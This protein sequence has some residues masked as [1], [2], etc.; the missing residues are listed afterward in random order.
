MFRKTKLVNFLCAIIIGIL[1][2]LVVVALLFATGVIS[3]GKTE[4]VIATGGSE[5][6]YDGT[7]LTNRTWKITK[8]MLKEGH[9]LTFS[10]SGVQTNVGESDNVIEILI[11]DELGADVTGDYKITFEYGKLKINPRSVLITCDTDY[12]TGI[13]TV[14][15]EVSDLY[16]GL[17]F[18]HRITV[19]PLDNI[20]ITDEKAPNF[21]VAIYDEFGSDVSSNYRI[22]MNSSI[23]P[24]EGFGEGTEEG[25][26]EGTEEGTEEGTVEGTE[27]SSGN[28][29]N[30]DL[31]NKPPVDEVLYYITASEDSFVYLREGSSGEYNGKSW[32]AAPAFPYVADIIYSPSYLPSFALASGGYTTRSIVIEP[33]YRSFALPYYT[34][35]VSG[36]NTFDIQT[37]DA[38]YTGNGDI[39]TA[40]YYTADYNS[41]Q[42][43]TLP[44]ELVE[45]E[46]VYR[47]YVYGQYMNVPD[48]ELKNHLLDVIEE[49][50]F[51]KIEDRYML[52]SVVS[53]YIKSCAK[54]NLEYDSSIDEADDIVLAFLE[55]KEGVCRHFASAATL[56]FRLLGVP[57]RYTY[58][59]VGT[60]VSGERTEIKGDQAHAWV[61]VY[62]DGI[63]WVQ[64]EVTPGY[65]GDE[66]DELI[67]KVKY[68]KPYKV[69]YDTKGHSYPFSDARYA[70]ISL[71]GF[72]ELA[73]LGYRYEFID[74]DSHTDPGTYAVSV[75]GIRFYSPEGADVTEYITSQYQLS[76]QTGGEENAKLTI[77]RPITIY[78]GNYAKTFDGKPYDFTDEDLNPVIIPKFPEIA[79]ESHE[80]TVEYVCNGI[81]ATIGEKKHQITYIIKVIDREN[82][83]DVTSEYIVTEHI[84]DV[85][86]KPID[87]YIKSGSV[88][89]N[90]TEFASYKEENG[91]EVLKCETWEYTDKDGNTIEYELPDDYKILIDFTEELSDVGTADNKFVV[92]IVRSDDPEEKQSGNFIIHSEFG[93]IEI[94]WD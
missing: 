8:G 48:G 57:A 31:S 87:I 20:E 66:P 32:L 54:Y 40:A 84:G 9:N 77:A 45:Y 91:V 72:D 6:K 60:A 80:I 56:M 15:A 44:D 3:L 43:L 55:Q 51:R 35:A 5:A 4:L 73:E 10:F 2:M 74:I 37:S 62:I 7:P 69:A 38:Y 61:E 90:E 39:Y 75:P 29:G 47:L 14:K 63:G 86:I 26:V 76:E 52:I 24:G 11:T 21:T 82:G 53:A 89:M 65:E 12:N 93:L 23:V 67:I 22:I 85:D 30:Q 28:G 17:V 16:D 70:E 41:F 46:Q 92:K 58:G 33:E 25:T 78:G 1:I 71:E 13:S 42:G 18:G 59:A 50:S 81:D 27:E 68:N 94:Y 64:V 19:Q 34:D 88:D 83:E 49:K 79:C 36:E